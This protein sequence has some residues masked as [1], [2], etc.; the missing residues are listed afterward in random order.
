MVD[1]F[2]YDSAT[3]FYPQPMRL[4][5]YRDACQGG[6]AALGDEH[7]SLRD[8]KDTIQQGKRYRK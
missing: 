6:L 7:T 8:T 5:A 1:Q 3:H 4:V 2:P